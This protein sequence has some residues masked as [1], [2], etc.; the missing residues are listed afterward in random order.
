MP[1][2]TSALRAAPTT[3]YARVGVAA[4][5]VAAAPAGRGAAAK[6]DEAPPAGPPVTSASTKGATPASGPD[7]D[8][9]AL[10]LVTAAA[11]APTDRGASARAPRSVADPRPAAA[12]A[13]AGGAGT[14]ARVPEVATRRFDPTP[15]VLGL[16]LLALVIAVVV[17][18]SRITAPLPPIGGSDGFGD[19]TDTVE[20]PAPEEPEEP[21]GDGEGEAAP[22]TTDE[23]PVPPTI[24]SATQ[25]DPPPNGDN[26]EHPEA[27][28]RAIDGDPETFWFSRTYASATYGMKAGIGYGLTL[29]EPTMVA[30]V[31][32]DVAGSGGNVEVRA[33]DPATPTE[34]DV[35]ASGPVG[36]DTVLTFAEPV[37]ASSI[38]LWWTELPQTA[39]GS[40]RIELREVS[41]AGP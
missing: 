30:S 8:T 2:S 3:P 35:L 13:G 7:S 24:A 18:V 17:A 22:E 28:D 27:V 31:T 33:T 37:R 16:V 34:G 21:E 11:P 5:A 12:G 15:W 14:L 40:N 25:I 38:V 26:N 1:S 29:A 9:T 19:V 36:P 6:P 10:P 23:P 20:S 4:G 32:L 39:D 41:V